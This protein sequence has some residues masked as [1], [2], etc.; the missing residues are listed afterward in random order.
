[1]PQLKQKVGGMPSELLQ[2]I[3]ALS[4]LSEITAM[5]QAALREDPLGRRAAEAL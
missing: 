4:A 5:L 2:S 3:G 1:M